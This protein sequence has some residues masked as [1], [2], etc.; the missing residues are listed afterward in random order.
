MGATTSLAY[1]VTDG[2]RWNVLQLALKLFDTLRNDPDVAA[3]L[4]RG[5]E[6]LRVAGFSGAVRLA[7]DVP[8][9]LPAWE[10]RAFDVLSD[11]AS[12]PP[13]R[14]QRYRTQGGLEQMNDRCHLKWV[15]VEPWSRMH[16]PLFSCWYHVYGPI[17]LYWILPVWMAMY[18]DDDWYVVEETNLPCNG[19]SVSVCPGLP[20]GCLVEVRRVPLDEWIQFRSL[21]QFFMSYQCDTIDVDD[22]GLLI[23]STNSLGEIYPEENETGDHALYIVVTAGVLLASAIVDDTENHWCIKV[24]CSATKSGGGTL[25]IQHLQAGHGHPDDGLSANGGCLRSMAGR[26][27]ECGDLLRENGLPRQTRRTIYNGL[28]AEETKHR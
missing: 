14:Y 26:R 28:V 2:Q 16:D 22:D 11:C 15:S 23:R 24:I 27:P 5:A 9:D 10:W 20:R 18:L 7:A 8:V 17:G 25:L 4:R 13:N 6:R 19:T 21:H 1:V 3:S 12:W